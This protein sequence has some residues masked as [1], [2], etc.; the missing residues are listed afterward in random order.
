METRY[1][2]LTARY[3]SVYSRVVPPEI[4]RPDLQTF[5]ETFTT[6]VSFSLFPPIP[7]PP[8]QPSSVVVLI[9][10]LIMLPGKLQLVCVR[11]RAHGKKQKNIRR[12]TRCRDWNRF[13]K[14]R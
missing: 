4:D 12:T 7:S 11:G 14:I 8:L 10:Q 6:F 1:I 3:G 13:R 5:L 2:L 9:R